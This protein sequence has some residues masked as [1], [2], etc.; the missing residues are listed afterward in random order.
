MLLVLFHQRRGRTLFFFTVVDLCLESSKHD[1]DLIL[2]HLMIIYHSDLLP[3]NQSGEHCL[4]C[5]PVESLREGKLGCT[6]LLILCIE[7]SL[8]ALLHIEVVKEE[9]LRI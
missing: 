1:R 2:L 3:D 4:L 5:E 8:L 7:D 9:I 6:Q